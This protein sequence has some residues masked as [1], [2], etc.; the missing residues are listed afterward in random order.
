M[1]SSAKKSPSTGNILLIKKVIN[2]TR[3]LN[4]FKKKKK[5]KAGKNQL[6][7]IC[8]A[9]SIFWKSVQDKWWQRGKLE[10]SCIQVLI[11]KTPFIT[12]GL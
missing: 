10:E 2:S 11:F 5:F 12:P 7:N 3:D 1:T 9:L 8:K 6:K 4:T